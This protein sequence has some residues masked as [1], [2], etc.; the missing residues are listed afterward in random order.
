M[1]AQRGGAQARTL[2]KTQKNKSVTQNIRI[3]VEGAQSEG[4]DTGL[5]GHGELALSG[6]L[7]HQSDGL[8]WVLALGRL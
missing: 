7:V 6:D 5:T 4:S 3:S 8:Y 2:R 1:Q